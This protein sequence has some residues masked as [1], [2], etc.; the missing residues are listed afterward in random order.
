MSKTDII[1]C[2]IKLF[3]KQEDMAKNRLIS[4]L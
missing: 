3:N 2:L 4:R 1:I